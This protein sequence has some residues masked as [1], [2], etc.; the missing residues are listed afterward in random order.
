MITLANANTGLSQRPD[1]PAGQADAFFFGNAVG[2]TGLGDTTTN[3]LV[4]SFDES[5][6]RSKNQ[7]LS[8]NIPITNLYDFNRN[9]SVNAVDESITRLNGTNPTTTLKYLNLGSPPLAP[10]SDDSLGGD[11]SSGVASAL[12]WSIN[13]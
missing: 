9:G 10:Q 8:A 12:A 4:N 5:G 1:Y 13:R 7:L 11:D 3:A 6:V 2:N